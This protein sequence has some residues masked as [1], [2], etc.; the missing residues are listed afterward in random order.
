VGQK[1]PISLIDP[2]GSLSEPDGR[3]PIHRLRHRLHPI[4]VLTRG[5]C[6]LLKLAALAFSIPFF[7]SSAHAQAND[8]ALTVGGYFEVSNPLNLGAAAALEGTFAHR[9]A[10]IPL[11]AVSAELP[12]AGSFSSS[13]P[14]VSGLTLA[15]SY[16]SL[17]ITP[18]VRVRFAPSFPL[19]PYVSAGLGYG[20]FNRKLYGGATSS[21]S[22][23]AF[24]IGGGL[25]LKVLPFIGVRAE[26]RD[27]NSGGVGIETVAFGRQ[28]NLFVT[29]G[30]AVRF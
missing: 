17:F 29:I 21:D 3:W 30:V 10:H 9:I 22:T 12:V 16:T 5:H 13:I 20:H 27:F 6:S 15:K 11:F 23:L 24:D 2:A 28:N 26:I 19:S 4:R 1:S 8:V 18:G 7:I 14:T 25:E